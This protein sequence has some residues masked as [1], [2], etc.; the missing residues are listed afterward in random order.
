[1]VKVFSVVLNNS[2][3]RDVPLVWAFEIGQHV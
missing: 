1:M 2:K 3:L